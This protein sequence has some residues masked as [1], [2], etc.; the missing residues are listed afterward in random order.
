MQLLNQLSQGQYCTH[1]QVR[2]HLKLFY[3]LLNL[4]REIAMNVHMALEFGEGE[5]R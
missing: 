5:F 3:I 2:D 4:E 1:V